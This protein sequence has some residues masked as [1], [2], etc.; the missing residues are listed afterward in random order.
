[1]ARIPLPILFATLSILWIFPSIGAVCI[2]ASERE[3][4]G[5]PVE[6]LIAVLLLTFHALMLFF[7]WRTGGFRALRR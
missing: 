4:R 1:M 7:C 2:L 6:H 5:I 3:G